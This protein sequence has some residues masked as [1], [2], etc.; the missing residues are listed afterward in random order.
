MAA[1]GV[2]SDHSRVL[3]CS[4]CQ[5]VLSFQEAASAAI[6]PKMADRC[7]DEGRLLSG[8]SPTSQ[9]LPSRQGAEEVSSGVP[10]VVDDGSIHLVCLFIYSSNEGM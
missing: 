6:W 8:R 3:L 4:K 9:S 2:T 7:L 5:P 10:F 1:A